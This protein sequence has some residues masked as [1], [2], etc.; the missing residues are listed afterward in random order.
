[1]AFMVLFTGAH[2]SLGVLNSSLASAKP[3]NLEA[4]GG[5]VSQRNSS[6]SIQQMHQLMQ[7]H[8]P[9]PGLLS[10]GSGEGPV[11]G[12]LARH[13]PGFG[14]SRHQLTIL[15]N[16]ILAFKRL[17]ARK[18]HSD[19]PICQGTSQSGGSVDCSCKCELNYEHS[20]LNFV[21]ML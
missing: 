21:V 11:P 9:R 7:A 1:M 8:M 17:K 3:S 6:G 15:R 18:V 4:A 5:E 19:T 14:F 13:P 20:V 2:S 12:Q 10:G 16:Q